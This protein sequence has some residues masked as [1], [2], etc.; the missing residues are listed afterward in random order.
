LTGALTFYSDAAFSA[1]VTAP[2]VIGQDTIYGKVT[3]DI[4]DDVSGE[5]YQ[6][7]DVSIEKI[8]VCTAAEGVDL[9]A[10]LDAADGQGGCLSS[11]IVDADG[12]YTVYG[13]GAVAEYQGSTDYGT[14][15][16]ANNEAAFSFLTFDTPR[17]TI[18]VHVHLL[19]T[20]VD[21]AER[22]RQ[23][24][25]RMLLQESGSTPSTGNAFRSYIGTVKVANAQAETED[26][27]DPV[28]T[29]D[30]AAFAVGLLPAMLMLIGW[31]MG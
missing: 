28:G 9:T 16:T 3:V 26:V 4:P 10:N 7:L 22:R 17:E 6:F 30:A 15:V 11:G 24:R 19:V 12:P 23:I 21:D 5:R 20:M 31:V 14:V 27:S 18:A 1:A 8:Y 25:R 2:F 13:N 29:N